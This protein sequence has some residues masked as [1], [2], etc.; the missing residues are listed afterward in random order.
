MYFCKDL[1]TTEY[2][3]H[4]DRCLSRGRQA[5]YTVVL[6]LRWLSECWLR[7]TVLLTMNKPQ[8]HITPSYHKEVVVADL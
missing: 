2:C 5:V 4:L 7:F 6:I 1:A 8:P 3:F